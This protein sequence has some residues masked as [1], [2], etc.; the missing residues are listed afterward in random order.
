ML[1]N[2]YDKVKKETEEMQD[3]ILKDLG[4]SP[5]EQEVIVLYEGEK[6]TVPSEFWEVGSKKW[7]TDNFKFI[8]NLLFISS[9]KGKRIVELPK[10]RPPWFSRNLL[11]R[12]TAAATSD[13]TDIKP[14]QLG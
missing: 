5:V 3:A 4:L 9:F 11:Q 2:C 6:E 7:I 10:Q 13:E 14:E 8:L 1:E 12:S